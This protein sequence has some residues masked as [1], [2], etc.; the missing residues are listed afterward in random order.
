MEEEKIKHYY[1]DYIPFIDFM[2]LHNFRECNPNATSK[3]YDM[4][5]NIIRIKFADADEDSYNKD[6][7]WFEFG[8]YDFG[9]TRELVSNLNYIF[10]TR[11]LKSYVYSFRMNKEIGMLE[12]LLT[13][14]PGDLYD[15]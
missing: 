13:D 6:G 15:D 10:S 12:V 5:T 14:Q 3:G 4:D 2:K 9:S 7:K 1:T 8:I 11:I